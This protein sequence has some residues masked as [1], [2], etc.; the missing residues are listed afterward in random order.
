MPL[1]PGVASEVSHDHDTV[2]I[3]WTASS[4]GVG[5][6]VEQFQYSLGGAESWSEVPDQSTSPGTFGVDNG[7]TANTEY[8]F[9]VSYVDS[10]DTVV[11]SNTVTVTTDSTGMTTYASTDSDDHQIF[12]AAVS[13]ATDLTALVYVD[14]AIGD[15]DWSGMSLQFERSPDAIANLPTCTLISDTHAVCA[16]HA[17]YQATPIAAGDEYHFRTPAG[18]LVTGT[19]EAKTTI[20]EDIALIRFTANPGATLAR[21]AI[22][23][24]QDDMVGRTFWAPEHNCEVRLRECWSVGYNDLHHVDGGWGGTV[25]SSG[26]PCV[27][28]LTT[29]DLALL[30]TH[31]T[32]G[33]FYRLDYALAAIQ[34]ELALHAESADSV[35]AAAEATPEDSYSVLSPISSP[36]GNPLTSPLRYP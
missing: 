16:R 23:L 28:P 6:V 4:G 1:T 11:Y 9:R 10:E 18:A 33:S 31:Y 25:A 36:V 8:D 24:D 7:I 19:V 20:Y 3:S 32:A 26:R 21:Y 14:G 15:Y 35:S 22:L 13:G 2:V 5:G 30:G 27:V 34:T 12:T 29:G 17:G